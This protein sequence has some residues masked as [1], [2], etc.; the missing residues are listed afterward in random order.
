MDKRMYDLL[1]NVDI[2]FD[3]YE[4][5]PLSSE[6]NKAV[7]SRILKEIGNMND[8]KKRKKMSWPA[9]RMIAAVLCMI[10]L[11]TGTVGASASGYFGQ[12]SEA[13]K[14][15]F[16]LDDKTSKVAD[17][18]GSMIG[19][20]V[21]DNGIK[22]TLDAILG[23]SYRVA[24]VCTIEKEDKS[25]FDSSIKKKMKTMEFKSEDIFIG[26]TS[27]FSGSEYF[28]DADSTDNAFQ[29][30]RI[31]NGKDKFKSGMTLNIKLKDIINYGTEKENELLVKGEWKFNVPLQYE[32]QSKNIASGQSINVNG[33]HL[34]LNNFSISSVGIY[35]ECMPD[36]TGID[37]NSDLSDASPYWLAFQKL[38]N[39]KLTFKD[40]KTM[41][42]NDGTNGAFADKNEKINYFANMTYDKLIDMNQ[43][44]YVTIHGMK[45]DVAASNKN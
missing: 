40:G 32:N 27:G 24:L 14:N 19:K 1:N 45:F 42:C 2:D 11:I 16:H 25:E 36:N 41:T 26:N 15:V 38:E 23:D 3:Q 7:K 10:I 6:E 43:L 5:I 35:L 44:D 17:E 33:I 9:K 18:E 4:E 34:K 21:T 8:N 28:Y 22:I 29:Y 20:S 13:F 31:C 39:I 30:V 37:R 12:V